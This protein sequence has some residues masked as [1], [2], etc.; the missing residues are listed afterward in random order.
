MWT[1]SVEVPPSKKDFTL[2]WSL[3]WGTWVLCPPLEPWAEG[4]GKAV[5]SAGMKYSY[6]YPAS[7]YTRSNTS[8]HYTPSHYSSSSYSPSYYSATKY[9]PSTLYTPSYYTPPAYTPAYKP[10]STYTAVCSKLSR[11]SSSP[12]TS[13][14]LTPTVTLKPARAVRFTN[15]VVFQD[16][17]RHSE[18]EQ[19]GRFMRARKVRLDT[20]FHSG[21]WT[22]PN[23]Q[24]ILEVLRFYCAKLQKKA[25]ALW[26]FR[27][28]AV[29][30]VNVSF[31]QLLGK[32]GQAN[33]G[34]G[35]ASVRSSHVIKKKHL[36]V[37]THMN[38]SRTPK[39]FWTQWMKSL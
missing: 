1:Q 23:L 9:S 4:R 3:I 5:A 13:V 30:H 12:R 24:L 15:D 6:Q 17:V 18:L 31:N 26:R 7:Q 16:L 32:L 28:I 29:W 36:W 14:Q 21:E 39:T 27:N 38:I 10:T 20:I 33:E 37:K 8:T 25:L 2:T 19:I 22:S 35:L 34:Q 11:Q